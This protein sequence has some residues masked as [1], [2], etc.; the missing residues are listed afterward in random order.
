MRINDI[1]PVAP[2]APARRRQRKELG[3]SGFQDILKD[4]IDRVRTRRAAANE[5][6]EQF[7]TGENQDLHSTVLATQRASLDFESA[8][9]GEK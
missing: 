4:A 6:V 5:A 2:L 8:S 9:S 1:L 7:V 3:A